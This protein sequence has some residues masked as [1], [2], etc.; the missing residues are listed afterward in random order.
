[1]A[2]WKKSDTVN[3]MDD[4]VQWYKFFSMPHKH[5]LERNISM[6]FEIN[7]YTAMLLKFHLGFYLVTTVRQNFF[8]IY[9]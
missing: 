2:L 6:A 1:M 3:L 7:N 8:L 5:C 9:N 4:S